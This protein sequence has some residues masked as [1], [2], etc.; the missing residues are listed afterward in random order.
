MA[1]RKRETEQ[2]RSRVVL[3]PKIDASPEE[4]AQVVLNAG[5]PKGPVDTRPGRC[6]ECQREFAYLE[7]PCQDGKC[8]G[9]H[10]ASA[11]VQRARC[12][13]GIEIAKA[14]MCSESD[15]PYR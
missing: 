14:S 4:A 15:C 11:S 10:S 5:R 2:G 13:C 8:E 12:T 3:P 7:R 9:C 6:V 1:G